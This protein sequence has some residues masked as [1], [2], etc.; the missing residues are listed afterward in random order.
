MLVYSVLAATSRHLSVVYLPQHVAIQQK[1]HAWPLGLKSQLGTVELGKYFVQPML[2]TS[3]WYQLEGVNS[4]WKK[5]A[6]FCH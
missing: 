6:P 1:D 2:I 4:V 3:A 5:R